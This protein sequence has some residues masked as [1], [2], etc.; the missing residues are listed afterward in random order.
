MRVP[1]FY[2]IRREDELEL[3]IC[4]ILALIYQTLALA[5]VLSQ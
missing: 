1:V 5:R 2:G 4:D 3:R